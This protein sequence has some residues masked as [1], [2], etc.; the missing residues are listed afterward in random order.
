MLVLLFLDPLGSF[1]RFISRIEILALV[2]PK[3]R[4]S[5][6]LCALDLT[7]RRFQNCGLASS[8]F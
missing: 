7:L 5:A 1:G 4:E 8:V 6:T 2:Y 3:P